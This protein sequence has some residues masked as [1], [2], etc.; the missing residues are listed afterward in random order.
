[1]F[2]TALCDQLHF[3]LQ[4]DSDS[5]AMSSQPPTQAQLNLAALAGS[6]SPRTMRGL[7][8]IQSHHN[9]SSGPPVSQIS[10]ARSSAGPD[11]LAKPAQL[12]SPVRL[13]THRRARSNSDASSREAPAIPSVRRPGRKTG[14][15]FGV[16]RSLLETLLRDGPQQGN[17][18]QEALQELRYL[19]LSTRVEADGDGM[20][21]TPFIQESFIPPLSTHYNH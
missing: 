19:V 21:R 7:R 20:V 10:S 5:T 12:D 2:P 11:E 14:S 17:N 3:P 6:P 13:R 9:L 16:K 4:S 15:G 8:K 1:V 18:V